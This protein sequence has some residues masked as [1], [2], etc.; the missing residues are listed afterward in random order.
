M[1]IVDLSEYIDSRIKILKQ[2]YIWSKVTKKERTLL[3][4]CAN[5]IQV[6]NYMTM[7]RRKYL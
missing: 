3:R 5:E 1:Y 2:M 7:F 4:A 6:D